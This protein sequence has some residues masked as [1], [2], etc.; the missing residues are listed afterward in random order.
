MN[1]LIPL[2]AFLAAA[3]TPLAKRILA[4]LGL[5]IL[6]FTAVT[7]ALNAAISLAQGYFTGLPGDIFGLVGLAGI[8]EGLGIIAGAMVARVAFMTLKRIGVL[9]T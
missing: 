9:P 7:T 5:G 6:S 8:G 3:V 4:G 1:I 2:G